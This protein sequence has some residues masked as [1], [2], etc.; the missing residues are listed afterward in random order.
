M[1][2][3]DEAQALL[4]EVQGQ[5]AE[6]AAGRGHRF[7]AEPPAIAAIAVTRSTDPWGATAFGAWDGDTLLAAALV[8]WANRSSYY[9]SGGS[10]HVGYFSH[11]S[12]WL[13]LRIMASLA[14]AG[15]TSYNLGG[16]PASAA[17]PGDK[18]H[19]LLRFKSDFG[20]EL[21]ACFGARWAPRSAHTRTHQIVAGLLG[22][23][24]T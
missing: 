11:A 4:V 3:G 1:L 21:R 19:G 23:A 6:R 22:A 9:I 7:L 2:G 12:V 14:A 20:A 13:Q 8:G 15:L 5:A 17:E 18:Q 16:T 24:A 10:T